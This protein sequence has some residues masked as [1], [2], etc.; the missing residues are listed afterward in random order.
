MK[1]NYMLSLDEEKVD[2]I[3]PWLEKNGMTFSGYIN[4]LIDEQISVLEMFA[5]AGDK[6]KVSTW[7]LLKM[8]SKMNKDLKKELK[9]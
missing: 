8:A 5:P 9:K 3:K 4:A 7:G 2:I 1:K 6:T